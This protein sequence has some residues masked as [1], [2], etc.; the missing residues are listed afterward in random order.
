MTGQEID[1]FIE[2]WQRS[3]AS[4]R[5]N[6]ALFLVELCDVLGLPHP[7]PA[8]GQPEQDRYVFERPVQFRNPDGTTSPGF[9]DL[10]R[11]KCFVL[12]TKQGC[13]AKQAK[14]LT[15]QAGMRAVRQRRGHGV[16]GS[17]SWDAAMLRARGQAE[18]YAKALPDWPPF[19]IVVDVGHSI[20][21]Y[22]D[23]TGTGKHYAQFPDTGSFRIRLADLRRAD[24]RDRFAAIWSDPRSLDPSQHAAKVTREVAARLALLGRSLEE[25]GHNPERVATFLMRCLFTMFAQN[26]GLLPKHSFRD[27]LRSLREH[28]QHFAPMAKAL[29]ESM[30]RGGFCPALSQDILRFNGGLFENSDAIPLDAEQLELLIDAAESDWSAVEP[31]IFGT[32]LERALDKRERER[33]GAH[34]T[35]RAYVERL[36]LPTIVEPLRTDWEAAKAAAVQLADNG[37]NAGALATVRRFHDSLCQVTV[38]DPACGT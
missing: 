37:D 23:F 29:W 32:L 4:E 22:A 30:D 11:D 36:V 10:Y 20:E 31:A 2:R 8:T 27:A 33:L 35:P 9:I 7:E 13:E 3:A 24:I 19:L 15:E 34:Y 6:Y 14:S 21:T 18:Q 38:L 25:T 16:R 26:V 28:P 5:A 12:E 1:A 17:G